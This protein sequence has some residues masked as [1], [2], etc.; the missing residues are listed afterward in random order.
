MEIYG[1]SYSR[2]L[3]VLWMACEQ[4]AEFIHHPMAVEA[5]GSDPVYLA[6]NPAGTLPLL[7]EGDFVLA[8][9]LAITL[10]LARKHGRLWPK[11]E[12]GQALA[13]QW[14]FW[15][16]SSLEATYVSWAEQALCLPAA[17][18]DAAELARAAQALQRPLSRLEQA[19]RDQPYLLGEAFTAADLN[20]AGVING[21]AAFEPQARPRLHDWLSR[22]LARPAYR[23]ANAMP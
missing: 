23:R 11:D 17:M 16:Q 22:C 8:E 19:L 15:A 9:S 10:Y 21:L 6:L 2:T 14:S 3:R 1:T 4:E 13:L 20:V 12:Q 7:K 18:R 5:C